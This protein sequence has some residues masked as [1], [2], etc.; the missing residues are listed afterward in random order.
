MIMKISSRRRRILIGGAMIV[1]FALIIFFL[2]LIPSRRIE[3]GKAKPFDG[4]QIQR[5]RIVSALPVRLVIPKINIDAAVEDVGLT[6]QGDMDVPKGPMDVAWFDLGPR[7]G[8]Q[9]SAVIAGHEGWKN[10]IPAVF[11]NLHALQR[12]DEIFIK[13]DKGATVAFVVR[14]LRTYGQN[15]DDAGVFSSSDGKAHLNL[16]T[17]Q[18]IWNKAKKSYSDRLVVF[19]DKE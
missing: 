4:S 14:G 9:G 1:F 5:Q 17:C 7:P 3:N 15:D 16:I 18:G 2:A 11:D 6:S 12:G 10:N 13:S 8:E 19:T